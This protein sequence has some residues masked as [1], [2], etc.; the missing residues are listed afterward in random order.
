MFG[1]HKSNRIESN[2]RIETKKKCFQR[3]KRDRVQGIL[4]NPKLKVGDLEE[5][6]N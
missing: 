5:D 6:R 1:S 2:Y 4:I 3:L